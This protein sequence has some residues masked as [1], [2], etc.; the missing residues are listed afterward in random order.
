MEREQYEYWTRTASFVLIVIGILGIIFV[1]VFWAVTDRV[2]L[3]FLPFFG[4]LAGVGQGLNV[5][6]E[7]SQARGG[8]A[9]GGAG[10][11]AEA[12]GTT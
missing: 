4:T 11:R 6:K 3:A 7:I 2:V 1:P 12:N 5:L 10:Q 9:S 8:G